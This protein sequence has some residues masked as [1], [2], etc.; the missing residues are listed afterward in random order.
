MS[1]QLETERIGDSADGSSAESEVS[2]TVEHQG[3]SEHAAEACQQAEHDFFR[4]RQRKCRKLHRLQ[5]QKQRHDPCR[6]GGD[7][8][9]ENCIGEPFQSGP[10]I[11]LGKVDAACDKWKS[12]NDEKHGTDISG[13][14][15]DRYAK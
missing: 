5:M 8:N 12:G 4:Q 10:H 14:M 15:L 11:E 3:K 1:R 7:Q 9:D 13:F 6:N 2:G